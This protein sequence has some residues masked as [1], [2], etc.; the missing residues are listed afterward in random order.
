MTPTTAI[1]RGYGL[2]DTGFPLDE[3][4]RVER[5]G[6]EIAQEWND[7]TATWPIATD[8]HVQSLIDAWEVTR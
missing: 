6:V 2:L 3:P 8:A 1:R 7:A 5:M 4:R